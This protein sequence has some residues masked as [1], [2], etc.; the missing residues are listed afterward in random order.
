MNLN[1][2]FKKTNLSLTIVI[3][4]GI[5]IV[6][7]FFSY[8]IFY[9]FDLT[10]NKDYSLSEASKAAAAGAKDIINI[11]VYFSAD[12][13][14]Q[15]LNLR[16]EVGDI[17]DEYANY[18]GGKIKVEFVNPLDDQA[19]EQEL[20][21]AGIP[22]LQFNAL[23][24][25]KYQVIN[26]YLGML[27]KYGE[28]SQAIPVVED[29]K[30]LEYKITSAV[31]KLTS[32]EIANI[33]FWQGNGAADAEKEVGAA[34]KK[35]GEIYNVSA[36][37]YAA[38][39][40]ITGDLDTLIIIGPKEKF[41]DDELKAIDAFLMSGGSLVIMA[42]GV[43]VEQGLIAD[44]ND[45]GLNKILE[46]YG[47]KLNEN[48][49]LDINNGM[50]SFSQGFVTFSVNY[51]YWP[52]VIN[53]GF[54]QANPAVS[55]LEGLILPWASTIDVLPEKTK[56]MAV[57]YLAQTSNQAL[58][59]ADNFKLDPQAQ[60]NGGARGKFNLAVALTGEFK[61]PFNNA[62]SK[63][64]RLILVGDSDFIRDNFL[65]NYP[66]NLVFF[67]NVIDGLSLGGDLISIRSKG[68]TERPLK[69]ISEAAKAAV[70]Y[71][72]IFGLT[73][74]VVLFGLVR[75]FLRRKARFEDQI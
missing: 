11:K 4:I 59:V 24:K 2:F 56:D 23:E 69:E 52:K 19:T 12:L 74:I 21:L 62:S 45:L 39:K 37:D 47:L 41:N 30:D 67:Q 17:L 72:N 75:Y 40:K 60:I 53:S 22:K 8:N 63:A 34:Y 16:Q 73:V 7:N 66:D 36:V 14:P 20:Y 44:K 65:G 6:L 68:V 9:R 43:K 46:S 55:R 26:G 58:A 70:R 10:Q 29:T 15:F 71:A 5:L 32:A 49:A 31:K 57:S 33:G 54:D 50:A 28:K 18:S 1:N 27:I 3:V 48:L 61:S 13:P 35:L 51:P 25:D 64:G 42:D 38:D